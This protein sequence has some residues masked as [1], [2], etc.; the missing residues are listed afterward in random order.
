MA[1]QAGQDE[2]SFTEA[3]KIVANES[4]IAGMTLQDAM[5]F[6]ILTRCRDTRLKEKMSELETPTMAEFN[7]LIDA[8]MHAKVNSAKSATSCG[9][10]ANKQKNAG[11][12][13]Q[14]NSGG[15]RNQVSYPEK[16]FRPLRQ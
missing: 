2:R 5:C 10:T 4:G 1:Q 9:T 8:H 3:V 7:I 16:K 14:I 6:V 13:G 11:R 15:G 12:V